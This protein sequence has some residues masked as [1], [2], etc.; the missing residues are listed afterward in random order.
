[1]E[2]A[3]KPRQARFLLG[4]QRAR[5]QM[6]NSST[7]LP[8]ATALAMTEGMRPWPVRFFPHHCPDSDIWRG[9]GTLALAYLGSIDDNGID[10]FSG[11][12]PAAFQHFGVFGNFLLMF[13]TGLALGRFILLTFGHHGGESFSKPSSS[14]SRVN[15]RQVARRLRIFNS[16]FKIRSYWLPREQDIGEEIVFR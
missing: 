4:G 1:M 11:S 8:S 10:Q 6:A 3:K 5:D 16:T 12:I 15:S 13:F 9:G 2:R 14:C 7:D